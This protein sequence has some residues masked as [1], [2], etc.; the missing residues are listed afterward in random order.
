M[1]AGDMIKRL[2]ALERIVDEDAPTSVSIEVDSDDGR[3][4][5]RGDPSTSTFRVKLIR[6]PTKDGKPDP[7]WLARHPE[8]ADLARDDEPEE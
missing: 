8:H 1:S 5:I 7:D 2:S 4:T 6:I 3:R